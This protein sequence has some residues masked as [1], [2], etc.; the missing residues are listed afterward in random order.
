MRYILFAFFA[1]LVACRQDRG[2]DRE[3][4][5]SRHHLTINSFDTLNAL[6]LGNGRFAM[7]MDA[8]GLQTFPEYY[9]RG[10]PLGTQSEWG[11]HSFPDTGNYRIEETLAPIRSHGRQ[12]PYAR[13]WPADTRAGQAANY[14]RQ[15]PHRIHLGQVGW[16]LLDESGRPVGQAD[17]E[18]IE[19]TLDLWRGELISSFSFNQIPVRVV[20]LI[21]Q[22]SDRL[23]VRVESDLVAEGRLGVSLRYPY[24]TDRWLD[25]AAHYDENEPERLH[26]ELMD[27]RQVRIGRQLDS[28]VYHTFLQSDQILAKPIPSEHGSTI[29]PAGGD[30]AWTF[31]VV[32]Q[33]ND[34]SP[35]TI[36]FDA[37][38]RQ[39]QADYRNFWSS[40]GM[41]DFGEVPDPRAAELER[42]MILSL[43]LTKVNCGGT[44]P[45]QET[46][47]TYNSWYGKPHMEMAWWHGVHFALWGRP[48]ILERHMQ[49]YF[50]AEGIA[51][52]IAGRQGFEG[53]RWQ[54]MTDPW[55]G[56]TA[57]STGSYLIWQ[58]PHLIYFAELLYRVK[59]EEGV[60]AEYAY[61]VDQTAAFMADFAWLD[62]GKDRYILGPGV[63]PAQERFDPATTFNPTYELAYW[64]WGL[65]TAQ[66]WRER[67]GLARVDKWDEVLKK[68]SA[69]P[70]QDG[71]YLAT[72]S[73][74]DSYTTERYMTD[75][76]S[77]LGAFGMLP[78]TGGLDT[79]T[80]RKTFEKVWSD[81]QWHDTWG[82]DFP[83][84]AMTATRLG[85]PERA[86]D[87]LLMDITTNTYLANGHNYQTPR[88]RLYL[89]G[90]G[91]LLTA[92]ALMA[93]GCEGCPNP[94]PGFP[95]DWDLRWEGLFPLY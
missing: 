35:P 16:H 91:G 72:E 9:Q 93:A 77:V 70:V 62:P 67:R 83:M 28:S 32:F 10:I 1:L 63:I 36:K 15:N 30:A 79:L 87:A 2:I 51:R 22:R 42:R 53:V 46:G 95:A 68:L 71:V 8:T 45:P 80:M 11:W 20:T 44:S 82:W 4:V 5:V 12:V 65:E 73:A 17:L 54:K 85:D 21:D 25:E 52:E 19:Q 38:R 29:Y 6:S 69:L 18:D 76:P 48:E 59:G 89:P 41:I 61:L 57:S 75:H 43:Y 90:N 78:A 86:V 27:D 81:W 84:T 14:L 55:G 23:A 40:G 37:L 60:L 7:T 66:L 26:L 33:P 39:V 31:S 56:E 92:L 49:W 13:Q 58:Q 24:P 50:R 64:R 34:E 74:P 3:A 88:L 94:S 47:L